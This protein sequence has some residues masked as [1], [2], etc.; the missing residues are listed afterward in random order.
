MTC[1][2]TSTSDPVYQTERPVPTSIGIGLPVTQAKRWSDRMAPYILLLSAL[3][4]LLRMKLSQI[5]INHHDL[6]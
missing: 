5:Y 3:R 6:R 2:H 1:I 4:R